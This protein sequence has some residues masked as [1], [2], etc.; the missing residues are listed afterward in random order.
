M[1][2]TIIAHRVNPC[3]LLF[4]AVFT[5]VKSV[6]SPVCEF[7]ESCPFSTFRHMVVKSGGNGRRTNLSQSIR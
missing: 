4:E 7:D 5:G 1:L 2:N 6:V 3:S